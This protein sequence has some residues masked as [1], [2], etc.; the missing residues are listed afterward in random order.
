MIP[1]LYYGTC[2][3]NSIS[4]LVG[5]AVP[6]PCSCS[7]LTSLGFVLWCVQHQNLLAELPLDISVPHHAIEFSPHAL[8]LPLDVFGQCS[9]ILELELRY[10][11]YFNIATEHRLRAIEFITCSVLEPHEVWGSR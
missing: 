9:R 8:L 2:L 5:A 11:C 7:T 3:G 4:Q 10:F 1:A 6:A